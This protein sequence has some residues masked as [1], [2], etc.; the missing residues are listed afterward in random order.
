MDLLAIGLGDKHL[1]GW[2]WF[3]VP[4]VA[5]VVREVDTES[6][7][8]PPRDIAFGCGAVTERAR[9]T[10]ASREAAIF[11]HRSHQ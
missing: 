4:A 2:D 7:R 11:N 8:K 1:D 5:V 6:E 10:L 9:T 3:P